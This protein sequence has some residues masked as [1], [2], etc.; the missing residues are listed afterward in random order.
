MVLKKNSMRCE[1]LMQ[2]MVKTPHGR[3]KDL[4]TDLEQSGVEFS[5]WTMHHTLDQ[6]G[7]HG[8]RRKPLLKERQKKKARLMFAK[9]VID[10]PHSSWDNVL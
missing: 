2:I 10:E 5:A 3:C 1:M 6:V 7:L 9:L 4:R 8:G